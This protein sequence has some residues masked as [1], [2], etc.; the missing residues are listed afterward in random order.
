[1]LNQAVSHPPIGLQLSAY[2]LSPI[3]TA[4]FGSY[5][6]RAVAG[7]K[8]KLALAQPVAVMSC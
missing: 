2:N 5:G 8:G 3:G 4:C 1:M 6:T 7:T